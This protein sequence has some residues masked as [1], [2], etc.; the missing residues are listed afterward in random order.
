MVDIAPYC[1][2]VTAATTAEALTDAVVALAAQQD[3]AAIPTL[4]DV[5]GYNNPAAAQAAVDGLIQLGDAAVEPLLD[6]LDDY[7]YGARAYEVRVLGAIGHPAALRVLLGAAQ[8]DFAPSVRRAAT[9]ALGTL[10]WHLIEGEQERRLGLEQVLQVLQRNTD[11]ADW[12]VRY[13]VAV[14][15]EHL[16]QQPAAAIIQ[17]SVVALLTALGDRDPDI[18]VRSR[19]QLALKRDT[20]H[21]S[22]HT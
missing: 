11:A 5:L 8:S 14:A 21:L 17:P 13:A 18:V 10:R 15:L 16:R 20:V 4:I 12:A 1:H 19:C 3:V 2:A 7:N 22:M 9:K 6:R